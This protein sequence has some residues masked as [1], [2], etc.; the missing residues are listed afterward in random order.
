MEIHDSRPVD[1]RWHIMMMRNQYQDR[2]FRQGTRRELHTVKAQV[3]FYIINDRSSVSLFDTHQ[4]GYHCPADTEHAHNDVAKFPQRCG[5]R[6][7]TICITISSGLKRGTFPSP[8]II[9]GHIALCFKSLVMVSIA[10]FRIS[11]YSPGGASICTMPPY[12]TELRLVIHI[13]PPLHL[14]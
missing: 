11:A 13:L 2:I 6:L 14:K 12:I 8:V 1:Y 7:A 9:L 5:A 4:K 3:T 10:V